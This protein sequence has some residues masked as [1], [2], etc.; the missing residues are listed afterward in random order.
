MGLSYHKNLSGLDNHPPG[1]VQAGD[2]GAIGVKKLWI[3]TSGGA[4]DYKIKIRN[5]TNSGWVTLSM[6][7]PGSLVTWAGDNSL[8]IPSGFLLCDGSTVLRS[9]YSNLFSALGTVWGSGDGST[10]FHIPDLRGRFLRVRDGG[11]GRD[12]DRNVRTACNPGG[13][14]GDQI[15]SVQGQEQAEHRHHF[16]DQL[17]LLKTPSGPASCGGGGEYYNRYETICSGTGYNW[18]YLNY[19]NLTGG[20]ETR[21]LNAY[22][23]M[24]IKY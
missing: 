21:P 19:T 7:L 2:P 24:I 3:D 23:N 8:G 1:Y 9:A 17:Y 5:D 12:P 11:A 16:N 6:A 18:L 13:K 14:V 22:V 15:G 10:T 20:N 4:G